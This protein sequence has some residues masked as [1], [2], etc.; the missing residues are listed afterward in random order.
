MKPHGDLSTASVYLDNTSPRSRKAQRVQLRGCCLRSV[1]TE[2]L[3]VEREEGDVR[4]DPELAR[5]G[6]CLPEHD[7]YSFGI[8]LLELISG[9]RPENV[10]E[11]LSSATMGAGAGARH[12]CD[13]L[14]GGAGAGG[15]AR[16]PQSLAS[17][18]RCYLANTELLL[19]SVDPKA[20]LWPDAQALTFVY[21]IYDMIQPSLVQRPGSAEVLRRLRDVQHLSV[22]SPLDKNNSSS[23]H[24]SNNNIAPSPQSFPSASP[25]GAKEESP[26]WKRLV[27][28]HGPE[29][30][31]DP[32]THGDGE[33]SLPAEAMAE[34]Q[35]R[36]W[37]KQTEERNLESL[38]KGISFQHDD[39][40]F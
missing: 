21:L 28:D 25:A 35:P 32:E 14:T 11:Q 13:N 29:Q 12:Q 38:P 30:K 15:S 17:V 18:L 33:G 19:K 6:A 10:L 2:E 37:S 16:P 8:I 39:F 24:S 23:H 9:Q 40:D 3:P 36:A 20:G 1:M 31:E 7:I 22:T 5:T 34:A 26:A 27:F 4:A